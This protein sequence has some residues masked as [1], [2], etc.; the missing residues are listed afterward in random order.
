M[1]LVDPLLSFAGTSASGKARPM[2]VA[3]LEC[4]RLGERFSRRPMDRLPGKVLL[5]FDWT[6]IAKCGMEPLGRVDIVDEAR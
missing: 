2:S 6:A 4:T 1:S 5:E 3:P